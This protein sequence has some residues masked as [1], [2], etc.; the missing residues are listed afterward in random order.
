MKRGAD[1]CSDHHLVIGKIKIRL[2]KLVRK[3]AGGFAIT[4]KSLE[5]AI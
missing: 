2:A 1:V 5:R 4:P 3:K